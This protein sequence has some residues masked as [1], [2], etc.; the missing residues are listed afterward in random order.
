MIVIESLN[1][2]NIP[3]QDIQ[4]AVEF[5]TLYLDFEEVEV[6]EKEAILSFDDKISIRIFLEKDHKPSGIYPLFSFILDIDDFTDALQVIEQNKIKIVSGPNENKKGE[7]LI[8]SDP[9]GNNIEFFYE[10]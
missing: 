10:E 8:I 3:A 7:S 2:I 6:K 5:Y 4:K 1:H 9:S